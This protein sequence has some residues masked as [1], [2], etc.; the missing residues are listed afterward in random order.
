MNNFLKLLPILFFAVTF[1]AH[2]E[3]I[4]FEDVVEETVGTSVVSNGFRFD[5]NNGGAIYITGGASCKPP[6][7]SNG[8]RTL[9]AAGPLL[10]YADQFTVSRA[11]GGDF[12]LTSIDAAELFSAPFLGDGALLISYEGFIRGAL[13]TSGSLLLDQLVDG[14]GGVPDFQTFALPGSVVDTFVF[15]G[16]GSFTGNDGFTLDNLVV[17]LV[18]GVDP[19]PDPVEVPEPGT[20]AL[21]ALGIIGMSLARRRRAG[22]CPQAN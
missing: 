21:G 14:P 6:C 13:V 3:V 20:F 10:G 4:D 7:A 22:A 17:E 8:T 1:S 12:R 5:A 19:D 18:G 11:A 15:T 2:G 9:L 16:M